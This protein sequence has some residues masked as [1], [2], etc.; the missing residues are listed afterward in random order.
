M[1]LCDIRRMDTAEVKK[2]P[3]MVD[4]SNEAAKSDGRS[5]RN[6]SSIVP[7]SYRFLKYTKL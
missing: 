4:K 5:S 7:V 1:L 3:K 6:Y 2:G